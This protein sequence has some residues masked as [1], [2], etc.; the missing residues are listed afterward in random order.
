M[1]TS[2][3][4]R[5]IIWHGALWIALTVSGNVLD[6]WIADPF[7]HYVWAIFGV[8]WLGLALASLIH[9]CWYAKTRRWRCL[10]PLLALLLSAGILFGAIALHLAQ[11]LEWSVKR[12]GFERVVKM[13][14]R[15]EL[16]PD[17]NGRVVLPENLR[18]LSRIEK[19]YSGDF[20][21]KIIA[22]RYDGKWSIFFATQNGIYGVDGYAY[23]IDAPELVGL[24]LN[25]EAEF[26]PSKDWFYCTATP[27][28]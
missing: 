24:Q 7:W 22:R 3:L 10:Q 5:L 26:R 8:A 27:N 12:R 21:G 9:I 2:V 14:E 15:G 28:R 18:W 6:D 16:K 19:Y 4:E 20:D 11:R 25:I 13:V 1:K 17:R 23:R